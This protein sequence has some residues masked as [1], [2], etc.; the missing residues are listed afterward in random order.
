MRA[1]RKAF[2]GTGSS[3]LVGHGTE[4]GRDFLNRA[5]EAEL[6]AGLPFLEVSLVNRADFDLLVERGFTTDRHSVAKG[7]VE[8][9]L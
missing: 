5:A 6:L 9:L 2:R 1:S 4:L 7:M 3:R 8:V